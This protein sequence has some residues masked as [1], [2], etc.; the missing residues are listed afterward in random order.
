MYMYQNAVRNINPPTSPKHILKLLY[1]NFIVFFFNKYTA[2][3]LYLLH[4]SSVL[5]SL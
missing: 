2:Y 4:T 1:Y 5:A 3:E